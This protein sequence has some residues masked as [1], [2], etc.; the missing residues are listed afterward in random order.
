MNNWTVK[1]QYEHVCVSHLFFCHFLHAWA[2]GDDQLVAS[3]VNHTGAHLENNHPQSWKMM[4][5]VQERKKTHLQKGCKCSSVK[6]MS[7]LMQHVF[8]AC[9]DV[10]SP[11]PNLPPALL[12]INSECTMSEF[13]IDVGSYVHWNATG[14]TH[15]GT[16]NP[17]FQTHPCGQRGNT[18]A[19]IRR[20]TQTRCGQQ[21]LV[22]HQHPHQMNSLQ[23]KQKVGCR[24]NVDMNLCPLTWWI[25]RLTAPCR[26]LVNCL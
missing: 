12:S 19:S 7:Q 24:R 20:P 21:G 5:N 22:P 2:R 1:E 3:F 17:A 9:V 18:G 13:L 6:E 23:W 15:P 10:S 16:G 14:S 8:D 4:L 25:L 11:V 26:F